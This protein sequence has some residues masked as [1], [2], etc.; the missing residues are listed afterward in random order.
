MGLT[1]FVLASA[2]P[3]R[4]VLLR[5]AGYRFE[6]QPAG[7]D[8][9]VHDSEDPVT[10]TCR[11]ADEKAA[12]VGRRRAVGEV[13]LAAD[14]SVICGGRIF[15]KPGSVQDACRQLESL[16]GRNHRVVTAWAVCRAGGPAAAG[17]SPVAAV[18]YSSSVVRMRELG[19]KEIEAYVELGESADKAGGYALQG[20]GGAL[21]AAV[22]GPRDNVV[23]L[24]VA[25]LV[26]VLERFGV[27]P[28]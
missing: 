10:A 22:I 8:E 1:R 11:I 17:V 28:C 13:V 16:A 15:G 9:T 26:P 18:G 23:G 7:I 20:A 12:A 19:R 27:S 5:E 24:P 3:R 14:T 2:S 6:V 21:I 4:R 25:Q